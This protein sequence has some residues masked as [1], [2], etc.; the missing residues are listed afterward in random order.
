MKCQYFFVWLDEQIKDSGRASFKQNAQIR[1]GDTEIMDFCTLFILQTGALFGIIFIVESA[2]LYARLPFDLGKL[3]LR[4]K[5]AN[6][7][8]LML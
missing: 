3:P 1:H 6:P 4:R 5:G 2:F 7:S 8:D